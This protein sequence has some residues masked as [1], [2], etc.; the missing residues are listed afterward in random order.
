MSEFENLKSSGAWS[1]FT[2]EKKKLMREMM[3]NSMY[4]TPDDLQQCDNDIREHEEIESKKVGDKLTT[5]NE[6]KLKHIN[7]VCNRYLDGYSNEHFSISEVRKILNSEYLISDNVSVVDRESGFVVASPSSVIVRI[8]KEV[9]YE[10]R[11]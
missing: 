11:R 6:Y 5:E 7:T 1:S 3:L 9:N 8:R 10:T 2:I 4:T